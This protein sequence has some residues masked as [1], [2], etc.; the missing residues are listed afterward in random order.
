MKKRY[1][2]I[3]SVIAGGI[4]LTFAIVFWV[5]PYEMAGVVHL[6]RIRGVCVHFPNG[7]RGICSACYNVWV[8]QVESQR[9]FLFE[10]LGIIMGIFAIA[11]LVVIIIFCISKKE[12]WN[13][14]FLILT[15][16]LSLVS[17]TLIAILVRFIHPHWLFWGNYALAV[18]A[19]LITIFILMPVVA[20]AII[21]YCKKRRLRINKQQ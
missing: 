1:Y 2:K 14:L 6:D 12:K 21:T 8:T 15:L 18:P 4:F 11:Y 19:F 3:L 20:I 17:F 9:A 16:A 10:M 13:G 7:I 5:F